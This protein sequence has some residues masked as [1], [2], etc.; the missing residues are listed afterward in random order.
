[1]RRTGVMST[2]EM[3]YQSPMNAPNT[4]IGGRMSDVLDLRLWARGVGPARVSAA[5][6]ADCC[7]VASAMVKTSL[8]MRAPP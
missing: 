8:L 3:K 1:M 4:R 7:R 5:S 2:Y 6:R